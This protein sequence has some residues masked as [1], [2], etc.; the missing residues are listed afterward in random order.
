LLGVV[1][2]ELADATILPFDIQAYALFLNQSFASIEKNYG[3]KLAQNNASIGLFEME[4]KT[5]KLKLSLILI[6]YRILQSQRE[7]FFRGLQHFCFKTFQ[8]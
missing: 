6:I 4:I 1:A 7:L 3:L 8:G 5:W 2:V